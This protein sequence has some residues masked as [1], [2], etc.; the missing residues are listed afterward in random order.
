M[1]VRRWMRLRVVDQDA[2]TTRLVL[3]VCSFSLHL[4]CVALDL[5][6]TGAALALAL[7]CVALA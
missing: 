2:A 1:R 5:A 3:H 4:H 7:M 6:L